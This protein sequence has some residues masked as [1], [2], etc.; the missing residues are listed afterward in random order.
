MNYWLVKKAE[1]LNK[2]WAVKNNSASAK[3]LPA[4]FFFTDRKRVADIFN[5]IR[6]L[7]KNC[8][9]IIR[10]YDLIDDE[11]LDF[12]KKIVAIAREKIPQKSLKILVGKDWSLARKIK[13]DGIHF[14]DFDPAEEYS[15]HKLQSHI[16][17]HPN[18][19]FTFSCHS[20]K[21][22]IKAQKSGCNL[23]FYSPIFITKSHPN[24]Q[25]IGVIKLRNLATK[26]HLPIYALGGINQENIK[27]LVNCGIAGIGGIEMFRETND[28]N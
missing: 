25:S 6:N 22:A 21:S 16:K 1:K 9:I 26:N 28:D 27:L 7:P 5:V 18:F 3:N 17:N 20:Q 12:A 14:S 15:K 8:A 19:L 2:N 24:Q 23:I 13:A 10:E 11:R 4:M